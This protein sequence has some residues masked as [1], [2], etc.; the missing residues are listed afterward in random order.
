V[1][2]FLKSKLTSNTDS[3]LGKPELRVLREELKLKDF[4]QQKLM[5]QLGEREKELRS[6]YEELSAQLDLNDKL[7]TQ[8]EKYQ[9]LLRIIS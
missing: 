6:L 4:E 9:K 7:N 3:S 1:D 5:W 8:L 2:G